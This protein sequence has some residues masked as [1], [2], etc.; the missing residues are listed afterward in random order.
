MIYVG[1]R[2]EIQAQIILGLGPMCP[3]QYICRELVKELGPNEFDN[4]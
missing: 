2:F 1:S 4:S 3:I